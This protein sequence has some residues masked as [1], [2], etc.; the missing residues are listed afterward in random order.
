MGCPEEPCWVLARLYTP[1]TL[2][3]SG[4]GDIIKFIHRKTDRHQECS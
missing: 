4:Y 3:G 1:T 2:K